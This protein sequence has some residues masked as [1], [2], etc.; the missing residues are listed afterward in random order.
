MEK[1]I[2]AFR[3]YKH[4]SW[5]NGTKEI[6]KDFITKLDDMKEVLG[7]F[8]SKAGKANDHFKREDMP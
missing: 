4:S 8:R 2:A 1:G 3:N 7:G 6:S 5:K